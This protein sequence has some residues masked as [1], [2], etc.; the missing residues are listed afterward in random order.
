MRL[1]AR[2]AAGADAGQLQSEPEPVTGSGVWIGMAELSN[3]PCLMEVAA[4]PQPHQQIARVLI[5]LHGAPVG[6]V[7]LPLQPVATLAE[8]VREAAE[9]SMVETLGHHLRLDGVRDEAMT[10]TWEAKVACPKRFRPVRDAA[11]V[12]IIV[13]TRERSALLQECLQALLLVDYAPLEIIVVD[14]APTTDLT[15]KLVTEFADRDPRVRYSCERLA[16]LARA[17]NHGLAVARFD[18]V[19]FTDDDVIVDVGW[20][21]A[22]AA[23]FAADPEAVCITGLVASRSLDT[24]AEVYFDSRYQWGEAFQPRRYDLGQHRDSSAIYPFTAG[25][26]GTGANFAVRRAKIDR[27]GGF[28]PALGAGSPCRG[29]EDLDIFVRVILSGGRLCYVPT[30]LV[31]HRHRI[32]ESA[33]AEQVYGYGYGLGAYVAKRIVRRE[34]TIGTLVHGLSRFVYLAAR[35]RSATK[36]SQFKGRGVR[37]AVHE[38]WGILAGALRYVRV[39]RQERTAGY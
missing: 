19:A 29:G 7:S 9:I 25:I 3:D 37:L 18:L 20:P 38:T 22:L 31:W 23:G 36:T 17:R 13:C 21:A 8:R 30:A 6:Y 1:H 26:F 28:D 33:L 12:S 5:R 24:Q 39:A 32:D 34:V 35:M 15:K 27:L 14:N 4:P 11:G 10:S 2:P 16:G